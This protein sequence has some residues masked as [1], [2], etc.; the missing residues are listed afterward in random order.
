MP[1]RVM[2]ALV[3]ASWSACLLFLL[4][5]QRYTSFLRPGF[6]IL[7]AVGLAGLLLLL[8]GVFHPHEEQNVRVLTALLRTGLLLIPSVYMRAARNTVS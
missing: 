1:M 5:G 2:A 3:L 7:L 6:G 4:N 8:W